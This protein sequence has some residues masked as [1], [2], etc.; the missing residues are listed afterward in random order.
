MAE[1]NIAELL[2]TAAKRDQQAFR[3]LVAMPQMNDAVIGFHRH[4]CLEK[5]SS[6]SHHCSIK[7]GVV[8]RA[9]SCSAQRHRAQ[10]KLPLAPG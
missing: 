10:P 7:L 8:Q 3:A 1:E 6:R 9:S 2:L 5:A 4:Q